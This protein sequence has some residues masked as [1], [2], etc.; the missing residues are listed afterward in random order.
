MATI[1]EIQ[2]SIGKFTTTA[3]RF[4]LSHGNNP[5]DNI[6]GLQLNNLPDDFLENLRQYNIANFNQSIIKYSQEPNHQI[7]YVKISDQQYTPNLYIID[8]CNDWV[9]QS[10]NR[11]ETRYE[12][13]LGSSLSAENQLVICDTSGLA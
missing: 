4:Q 5:I 11:D 8:E 10:D 7:N 9:G 1:S 3:N 13:L 6:T 12:V 2:S